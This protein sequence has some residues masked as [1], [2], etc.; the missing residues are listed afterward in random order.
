MNGLENQVVFVTGAGRGIGRAIA[1]RLAQEGARVAVTD[2]DEN[3]AKATATAIGGEAIAV[4]VDITDRESVRAGVAAVEEALGP[5]DVLINNAGWDKGELFIDSSEETW[6]KVIAINFVGPLNCF[7]AVLPGMVERKRGRIVSI[8]S[9]AGRAGSSGEAVYSGAKAG[10]IGFSKTIAR[11]VAR[12][13]INVNVVCPGPTDTRLLEE[14]LGDQ[15]KLRDALVRA[16]PFRRTAQP[17]DIAGAVAFLASDDAA[18]MTG[19][20]ISVSGGLTMI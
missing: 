19:Q 1:T 12:Y 8:S 3:E 6:E 18:Y 2:I 4:R 5:I 10:I 14:A 20:T 16:I 9:D 7:K 13:K 17:E 11:E 15:P